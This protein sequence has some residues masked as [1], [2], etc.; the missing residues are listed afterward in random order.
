[1]LRHLLSLGF[2]LMSVSIC[3]QN[4]NNYAVQLGEHSSE[5]KK[6]DSNTVWGFMDQVG[7]FY[8]EDF[9]NDKDIKKSNNSLQQFWKKEVLASSKRNEVQ[10][11]HDSFAKTKNLAALRAYAK[12]INARLQ[13]YDDVYFLIH[14]FRKRAYKKKDNATSEQDYSK[15]KD[16]IQNATNR[17]ILFVEVY[18]DSKHI[19]GVKALRKQRG[20]KLMEESSIPSALNA[21]NALRSLINHINKDTLNMISHSLGA[22]FLAEVL[23]TNMETSDVKTP[24]EKYIKAYFVAPAI[25]SESFLAYNQR[26]W[27][28]DEKEDRYELFIIYN[29][30][31]FVL[32][33]SFGAPKWMKFDALPTEH[34]N[35]SLGC[36]YMDDIDSL[37]SIFERNF[38]NYNQP[39]LIKIDQHANGK[40]MFCHHLHCYFRNPLFLNL[41]K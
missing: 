15:A 26:Y 39:I 30:N 35:T 5:M 19:K 12:S 36:N 13:R 33:K 27:E 37:T 21:G 41:I 8:P 32:N 38:S 40:K 9:I 18:W 31:D 22:V 1:M 6:P 29:P 11:N 10:L 3:A 23:F 28:N 14:G 24:H 7:W 20:L 17:R 34:G 16:L 4:W 2:F 25:G